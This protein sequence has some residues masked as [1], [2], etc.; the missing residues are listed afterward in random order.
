MNE[1]IYR[2]VSTFRQ[3]LLLGLIILFGYLFQ[4]CVIPYIRIGSVTPN[5][6][7][8]L[9]G[10]LTVTYGK[11]R[12][13]WAACIFGLLME[14]ML[15]SASY[16]NLALYPI[17]GLFCSFG[18][19][20][21]PTNSSEENLLTRFFH[22]PWIRTLLCALCN[23]LAHETIRLIYVSL[24][25]TTLT[26]S[27]IQRGLL[28][29]LSTVLLTLV[30]TGPLRCLIRPRVRYRRKNDEDTEAEDDLSGATE[31]STL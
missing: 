18:F 6:L 13:F 29:V 20:D 3:H 14:I 2:P 8:A 11:L 26:P 12:T 10:I 23:A 25:G 27:H 31:A 28:S 5:L 4:V 19:A 24:N 16:V 15:P 22:R 9:L 7:I 17:I 21:R 1:E 30:I